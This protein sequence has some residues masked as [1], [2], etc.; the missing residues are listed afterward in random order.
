[1]LA[2][3]SIQ[4]MVYVTKITL[5]PVPMATHDHEVHVVDH[6]SCL[7]P[8]NAVVPLKIPMTSCDASVSGIT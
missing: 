8:I 2:E 5:T 4:F 6:F 1:M 3:K 7:N